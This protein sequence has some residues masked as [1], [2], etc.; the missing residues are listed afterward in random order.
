MM[1]L[2]SILYPYAVVLCLVRVFS[3]ISSDGETAT[4]IT[5]VPNCDITL[6]PFLYL[7]QTNKATVTEFNTRGFVSASATLAPSLSEPED[8][9]FVGPFNDFSVV[10][11][12]DV[13]TFY[14]INTEE[15]AVQ[16]QYLVLILVLGII[17][18]L[19]VLEFIESFV[20]KVIYVS[21]TTNS[22]RRKRREKSL[23]KSQGVELTARMSDSH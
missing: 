7:K 10:L 21:K 9:L 17:G 18:V 5:G 22:V 8:Y 16:L 15:R 11:N 6:I 14:I 23:R 2:L 19:H 3:F 12:V 4:Q 13:N 1:G 20:N